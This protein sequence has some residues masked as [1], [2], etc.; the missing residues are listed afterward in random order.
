MEAF[1]AGHQ[2]GQE[3]IYRDQRLR[4]LRHSAWAGGGRGPFFQFPRKLGSR[5]QVGGLGS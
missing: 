5:L 1:E 4:E 2:G 3:G